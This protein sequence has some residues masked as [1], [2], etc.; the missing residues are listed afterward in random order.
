MLEPAGV[1]EH[2]TVIRRSRF[3][4]RAEPVVAPGAAETA[5][6]NVRTNHPNATH[7]VY[8]YLIGPP[9]SEIAG[10]TDAGEPKGTAGRPVLAVLRGSEISDCLVT[11]VRY[12]GG[13]KLGTGGLVRAYSDAARLVLDELPVRER[14]ERVGF[15]I[16]IPYSRLE[17]VRTL[18]QDRFLATITGQE[19]GAT[20]KLTG[21]IAAV[22]A[23]DAAAAI[24]DV[25]A[26][27]AAMDYTS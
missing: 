22:S 7:V 1:A 25:T 23:D 12:F 27:S 16:E 6:R 20:V 9:Q 15:V 14:I 4:A 17:P 19:Y 2:E 26:G 11:V 13:T 24:R 21:E 5:I 10:M 3:V 18:L 8:A